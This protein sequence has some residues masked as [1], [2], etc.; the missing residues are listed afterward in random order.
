[1]A[2]LSN[3]NDPGPALKVLPD[4]YADWRRSTLGRITDAL[5]ERLLLDRIGP[6]RGL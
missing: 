6:A 3:R 5:E 4:A 1:M 2:K